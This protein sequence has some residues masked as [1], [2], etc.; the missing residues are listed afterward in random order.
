MHSKGHG[1]LCVEKF[2]DILSAFSVFYPGS[3]LGDDTYYVI[4]KSVL[5]WIAYLLSFREFL[6]ALH[7][8]FHSKLSGYVLLSLV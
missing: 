1:H 2:V 5:N 3:S 6:R 8:E 7:P 4:S